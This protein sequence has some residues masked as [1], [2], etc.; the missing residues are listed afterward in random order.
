MILNYLK[1]ARR[2]LWKNKTN[3][4]INVFGLA[5]GITCC[6]GIY[7]FVNYELSFDNFH[8]NADRT[9]RIVE[10]SQKANGIQHW[11]TTAYPLAEALRREFPNISVTQTAGPDKRIIS[12]KD[13]KGEIRRFEEKRVMF[14]DKNYLR[15]FD[16]K[17]AFEKGLWLSGNATTAFSQPNS[18]VLTEQMAERYFGV[19]SDNYDQLIGKVLTLNN[20]D[21]LT[22]SGIIRNPP[23]NTNLPFDILI[24]YDFF[25]VNNTYQ[26]NNWSGNY[27]GTTY[28][29]LAPGMDPTKFEK[30]VDKLKSKYL[31]AEDNRRISY[32]LQPLSYIHTNSLY[33]SEPGTYVI[34]KEVL[35]GLSSL[36]VFLILIASVN[37]INLSTAQAMQRQKEIGV[38][39]AIGSSEGQLFFQFMSETFL[40]ALVAGFLSVNGLYALL[41]IVD[42]KLSFID[43][44]LTP[45]IQTWL[46]GAGL[47]GVITLL[48]GSYPA[49]V[50]SG[51]KPA[52][53]I[54][55]N[56][57]RKSNGI[58]LRQGLIV[59]QFGI[60]YCLLVATWISSD[61][62]SFFQKKG[63]GF[64]KDA[65]LTINAPRN[66]KFGELDAFRQELL[67]YHD[68]KEVSFASGAP[69]TKNWYGTDFHLKSEPITM[70]RQAE[71]KNTDENYQKLFGL[72]LV[73]G[74]WLSTSNMVPDSVGFNGFVINETMV[75]M[76]NLTPEKAIGEKLV[77]NEGEAPIIGVVKDFHNA[78]LQQAIQPCVFM[79]PNTPEQIHIQ[80][81]GTNGR[82]SNLSQTLAHLAQTWKQTFPDDVYQFTFLNES[83]AKN[84]FVEQLVF[85]A[86][87]TFAA[88][89]I[90]ISCLGLFG[91]ITLT[92]AQRTKEIGVRKVLGASVASVVGMLTGDFVKLVIYAIVLALPISWWFMNQWLQGFAYKT[93]IN[94]WIFVLSGIFAV[95]IALVTVSFQSIKAAL[96]DPVK[97]LK[98][99]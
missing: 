91:L 93:D 51:F 3:T 4:L 87:K 59:F 22:V 1:T 82:L 83:L 21:I 25:K 86:F 97:S 14:A 74:Q 18:V 77:I 50:L 95:T 66:K 30:A 57:Q 78:S 12:A 9:Y 69:L 27:L 32:F 76:L 85:D 15:L 54:K 5:L 70:S 53:A 79:Y 98:S 41:W 2:N 81:L 8:T 58:S 42:Q 23:A 17:N 94:G 88:I 24:N 49:F 62:M 61:Q 19:V 67:Q 96:M 46:F 75:K 37:F 40:L 33:A 99:E 73:A 89:S 47:I 63:L 6:L 44:N 36:A 60:T 31:N 48:A 68:I 34:G 45:T 26:A 64:T 28:V 65:V 55:N 35:W 7:V 84:Y 90:F 38:R 43:L 92:A 29:E 39:K 10:H 56:V 80:L 71:M 52:M 13:E 72:Q 11:P 16:F 20:T